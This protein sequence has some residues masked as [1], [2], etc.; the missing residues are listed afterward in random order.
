M[1]HLQNEAITTYLKHGMEMYTKKGKKTIL[2]SHHSLMKFNDYK[3][4]FLSLD[5]IR[6][7]KMRSF[8]PN[9]GKE[10]SWNKSSCK[11][12]ESV[13]KNTKDYYYYFCTHNTKVQESQKFW[14]FAFVWFAH[15]KMLAHW[16]CLGKFSPVCLCVTK[17]LLLP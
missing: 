17:I 13:I 2:I 14:T 5:F 11:R 3:C 4:T 1:Y 12:K 15:L 16:L 6:F 8:I 10:F 7:S 9:F